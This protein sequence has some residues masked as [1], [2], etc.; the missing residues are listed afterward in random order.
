MILSSFHVGQDACLAAA[1]VGKRPTTSLTVAG[2]GKAKIHSDA[3]AFGSGGSSI[4]LFSG[5][6]MMQ[7]GCVDCHHGVGLMR[8]E[9]CLC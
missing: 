4:C 6:R 7:V 2:K 3:C 8:K 9:R 5:R 1:L